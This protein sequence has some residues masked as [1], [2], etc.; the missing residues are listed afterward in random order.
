M[1]FKTFKEEKKTEPEIQV[2]IATLAN[3]NGRIF[4]G[5]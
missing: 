2:Q 1:D 4:R 3:C 5:R